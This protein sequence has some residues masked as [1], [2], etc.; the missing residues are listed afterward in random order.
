MLYQGLPRW[1]LVPNCRLPALF[2]AIWH[3]KMLFG[4]CS[5]VGREKLL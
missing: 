4:F 5:N 2:K 3:E 1:H